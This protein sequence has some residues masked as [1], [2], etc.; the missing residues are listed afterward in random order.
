[1][2]SR[3]KIRCFCSSL[4]SFR[5]ITLVK[6]KS[7]CNR[8][9]SVIFKRSFIMSCKD[10]SFNPVVITLGH[11][12]EK[13]IKGKE[14]S[15]PADITADA[16]GLLFYAFATTTGQDRFQR[17]Y[18]Q[19]YTKEGS[20]MYSMYMNFATGTPAAVTVTSANVWLPLTSERKVYVTLIFPSNVSV[21]HKEHTPIPKELQGDCA[22]V[23]GTEWSN[24]FI[25]GW[26]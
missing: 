7:Q 21:A 24:L 1:M 15:I 9:A 14:Y 20:N 11:L 22:I 16:K 8:K 6:S 12:P 5:Q 23:D 17:G 3:G 25:T 4:K 2:Y 18:F 26:K 13:P 10:V 19:I